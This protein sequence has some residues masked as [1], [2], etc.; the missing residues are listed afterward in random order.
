MGPW[1]RSGP[2]DGLG[3][4]SA[5]G[6]IIRRTGSRGIPRRRDGP[7]R[8]GV[9]RLPTSDRPSISKRCNVTTT[10]KYGVGRST[11]V[12]WCSAL[13]KATRTTTS[14]LYLGGRIIHPHGSTP[15]WD[16]QAATCKMPTARSSP[17]HGT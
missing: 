6:Q 9:R 8:P 12:T 16:L 4:W 15:A 5:E 7:T 2:P 14:C 1:L 17:M 10:V 3:I 13:S 11:S